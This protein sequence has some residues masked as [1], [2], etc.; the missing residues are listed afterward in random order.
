MAVVAKVW[1]TS[2][3]GLSSYVW[4]HKLKETKLDLK[5]WVKSSSNS[6][7]A[8]TKVVVQ[9][10]ANLQLDLESSDITIQDL[11]KEQAAQ[12]VSF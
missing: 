8:F 9:P 7:T 11:E 2:V 10:L 6:P 3:I 12:F 5:D 4:E 1:S